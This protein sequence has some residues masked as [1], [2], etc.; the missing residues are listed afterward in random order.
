MSQPFLNTL[1]QKVRFPLLAHLHPN[2][3]KQ[4]NHL[5]CSSNTKIPSTPLP[6]TIHVSITIFRAFLTRISCK[7]PKLFILS[8]THPL[9][10]T[11]HCRAES[12]GSVPRRIRAAS[13]SGDNNSGG[14][15]GPRAP[16]K[17]PTKQARPIGPRAGSS[18]PA[19]NSPGDLKPR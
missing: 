12:P 7:P 16:K 10:M 11:Q 9:H 17:A 19:H 13:H 15:A 6:T 3:Q 4:L 5:I 14:L 1:T 2:L 8:D 18:H